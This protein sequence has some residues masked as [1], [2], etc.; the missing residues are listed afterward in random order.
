MTLLSFYNALDEVFVGVKAQ[1]Y[2]RDSDLS[3]TEIKD[4]QRSRP[5][6]WITGASYAIKKFPVSHELLDNISWMLPFTTDYTKAGQVLSVAK[7]LPQVIKSDEIPVLDEEYMNFCTCDL[8]FP[9]E[10]I[11]PVDEYWNKICM[12]RHISGE[13][14]YPLLS[15]L[16]KAVLIIPHGNADVER[17]FGRVGLTNTKLRN[18]LSNQTFSA[19]LSLEINIS[20]SS[21]DFVPTNEMIEKCR[22]L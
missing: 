18:S 20:E 9:K 4:F 5:N 17:L 15:R 14:R 11:T 1:R 22:I 7:S 10:Y 13:F 19:L 21:F 16:A 12:I 8:P 6:F 2:L 3:N